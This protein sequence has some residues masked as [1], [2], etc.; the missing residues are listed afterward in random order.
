MFLLKKERTTTNWG[1]RIVSLREV[2][3]SNEKMNRTCTPTPHPRIPIVIFVT[4]DLSIR[5]TQY[6]GVSEGGS[7]GENSV[8]LVAKRRGKMV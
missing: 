7:S 3:A 5:I 4:R 1:A 8:C 6:D 2:I